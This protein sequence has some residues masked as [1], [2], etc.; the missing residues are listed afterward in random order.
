VN[1]SQEEKSEMMTSRQRLRK[2]AIAPL[3]LL[4]ACGGGSGGGTTS[5]DPQ[6][7]AQ[8]PVTVTNAV[9]SVPVGGDVVADCAETGIGVIDLVID[10]VD[11]IL[12][13]SLPVA[14]P[15]FS[16]VVALADMSD[17]PVIGGLVLDAQGNLV[18]ISIDTVT[19]MLPLGVPGLADLPIPTQLPVVC[20]SLIA[21]LPAGSL[22]D[23]TALLDTLGLP[24][25]VLGVIPI[26]DLAGD[27]VG[28]IL[29]TVPGGLVP[30]SGSGVTLPGVP[31][32]PDLTSLVPVSTSDLP[33]GGDVV[34]TLTGTV[35]GLLNTNG[36]VS[37][38]L[39]GL[40]LGLLP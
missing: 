16:D 40:V 1:R 30:G 27:P 9:N 2:L 20:S 29:A 35:L 11:S 34:A 17:V 25:G 5:T 39:L 7:Q 19:D 33:V 24:V 4:V 18:P 31:N 38:D 28:V 22:D 6:P 8:Q 3:A 26:F 21:F 15:K 14:L 36:L 23:P 13:S 37:G 12:G 10:A 32:L